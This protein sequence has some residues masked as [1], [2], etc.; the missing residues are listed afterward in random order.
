[1]GGEGTI[2]KWADTVP[3]L[4]NKDY[5]HFNYKGANKVANII[6][7]SFINDYNKILKSKSSKI[8]K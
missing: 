5:I 6:F 1:M 8:K 4:A 2:V 7:N 3:R